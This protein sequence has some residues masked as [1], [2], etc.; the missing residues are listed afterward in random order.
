MRSK[1]FKGKEC[2]DALIKGVKFVTEPVGS[3]LGPSGK[4]VVVV[5]KQ[6]NGY[7]WPTVTKDG[8]RVAASIQPED[9]ILAAGA[10]TAKQACIETAALAGD[11]TTTAAVLTEYLVEQGF[12]LVEQGENPHQIKAGMELAMNKVC[13]HLREMAIPVAG[14]MVRHV[15]TVSANGDETIGNNVAEAYSKVKSNGVVTLARATGSKTRV[16]SVG[17]MQI[18]AGTSHFFLNDPKNLRCNT[19]NPVVVITTEL[20]SMYK[21]I[22]NVVK[23]CD[24]NKRPLVLIADN[25]VGEAQAFLLKNLG[26]LS[27]CVISI[28]EHIK[29]SDETLKDI[30]IVTGA[31]VLG[32][33]MGTMI[34]KSTEHHY[35]SARKVE[36]YIGRAVI[37]GNDSEMN[38]I[39]MRSEYIR[40]EIEEAGDNDEERDR[41]EARLAGLD[42][43]ISVIHV[44]ADT[45]IQVN[46][47]YDRYDDAVRAVRGAIKHGVLAGGGTSLYGTGKVFYENEKAKTESEGEL[48]LYGSLSSP[49][50]KICKNS[51]AS[52]SDADKLYNTVTDKMKD[53]VGYN[54]RTK[55]YGDMIEMGILDS[56][57]A[58]ITAL[59]KAVSVASQ[60][61]T[62]DHIIVNI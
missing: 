51:S 20:I 34:S 16:E 43:G 32:K 47:L 7:M 9:A 30:A 48:L 26:Q 38:A 39:E 28:P 5:E 15:A 31:R 1:I 53:G 11:S 4:T 42:G 35:G 12:K 17:G 33:A 13:D 54:F 56:A 36:A 37:V 60:M 61:I 3:T 44:G 18:S 21:D 24:V 58:S 50:K 52:D 40:K 14:D 49:L 55:Q 8:A 2:R 62:T 59:Q 29:K 41:L 25:V 57:I 46:E 23:F 27:S 19:E 22:E 6:Q 45:D 10:N